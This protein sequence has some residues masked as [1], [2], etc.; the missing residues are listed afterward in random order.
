MQ[1][2]HL[3]K[4]SPVSKIYWDKK[5]YFNV[6]ICLLTS[7]FSL[8]AYGQIISNNSMPDA[9]KIRNGLPNFFAKAMNG[10]SVTVAYF[11]G[12]ITAQNGWRTTSLDW[13]K[14]R[15]PKARFTEINAAIGGTGSDFG[16][17]RLKDHVLKFKPDLVFV[18][19]AVND[20]NAS[21]EKIIRSMEGIVRQ[22]LQR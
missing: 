2:Y 5:V 13:F 9:L 7:A 10:D 14:T 8:T 18:E 1:K 22:T 4:L 16:V 11:G 3:L 21:S 6:L 12:S 20:G 17:F 19:F 15:F